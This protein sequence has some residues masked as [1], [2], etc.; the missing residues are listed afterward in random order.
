M[1]VFASYAKLFFEKNNVPF[2]LHIDVVEFVELGRRLLRFVLKRDL[3]DG[4][5]HEK[6]KHQTANRFFLRAKIYRIG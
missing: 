5:P 1:L 2:I 6:W 4:L 3:R